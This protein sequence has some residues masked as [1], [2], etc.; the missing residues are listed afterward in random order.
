MGAEPTH[1]VAPPV[2]AGQ[3]TFALSDSG[4]WQEYSGSLSM[5]RHWFHPWGLMDVMTVIP[6]RTSPPNKAAVFCIGVPA[7][8]YCHPLLAHRMVALRLPARAGNRDTG[9]APADQAPRPALRGSPLC[10]CLG[11]VEG[12]AADTVTLGH[13]APLLLNAVCGVLLPA[14]VKR[15]AHR[16][17]GH[18]AKQNK[19]GAL[20]FLGGMSWSAPETFL[21]MISTYLW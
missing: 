6:V 8:R 21:R 19:S 13:V 10:P 7:L 4:F 17:P 11:V 14:S 2:S 15:P 1:Q 3:K 5:S 9:G 16:Q 18:S 12:L 20:L